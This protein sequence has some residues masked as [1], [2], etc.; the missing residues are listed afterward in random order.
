MKQSSRNKWINHDSDTRQSEKSELAFVTDLLE[1]KSFLDVVTLCNIVI[2]M[3][4]LDGRT[5]GL[6][7]F[8]SIPPEAHLSC[9]YTRG[10]CIDLLKW[11]DQYYTLRDPFTKRTDTCSWMMQE[12]F[13]QQISAIK[14]H[15]NQAEKNGI[16]GSESAQN[17]SGEQLSKE[18]DMVAK[19]FPGG[20]KKR[21]LPSLASTLAW[22]GVAYGVE[23][24]RNP[25]YKS[26]LINF[27][28]NTSISLLVEDEN[29]SYYKNLGVTEGD[30]QLLAHVADQGCV[31]DAGKYFFV[32]L[33]QYS[34]SVLQRAIG[35]LSVAEHDENHIGHPPQTF[36]QFRCIVNTYHL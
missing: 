27:Y 10:K 12:Y 24:K 31:T 32:L 35:P 33:S 17:C 30:E 36:Q 23:C 1:F 13:S 6:A 16:W 15:K 18:L 26:E 20:I 8:G 9:I 25:S 5:Y 28:L 29:F 19:I 22:K 14:A 3:N 11:I 4:A 21:F 7:E 34:S 2:L